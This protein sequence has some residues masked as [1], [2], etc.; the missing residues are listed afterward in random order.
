MLHST[1]YSSMRFWIS[2]VLCLSSDE[3]P[4]RSF[5]DEANGAITDC[6]AD[7]DA[8]GAVGDLLLDEPELRDGFAEGLAVDGRSECRC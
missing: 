1:A 3:M 7:E 2:L 8:R 4:A 6:S 5:I